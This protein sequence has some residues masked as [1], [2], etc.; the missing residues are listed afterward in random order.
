MTVYGIRCDLRAKFENDDI[1]YDITNMAFIPDDVKV[2]S[3]C[4]SKDLNKSYKVTRI[5]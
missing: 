4:V 5:E 1:E 3:I 2:D